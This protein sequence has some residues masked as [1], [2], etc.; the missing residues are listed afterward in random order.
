MSNHRHVQKRWLELGGEVLAVRRTGEVRY[1]HPAFAST[2]RAN[3]R[4]H[5]APAIVLCRI[6]QLRR[7]S[8]H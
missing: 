3:G 4:R 6:E 1:V 2:I 8:D 7:R 5:D